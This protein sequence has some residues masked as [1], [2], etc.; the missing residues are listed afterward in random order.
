[1]IKIYKKIKYVLRNFT[2]NE[3]YTMHC[4]LEIEELKKDILKLQKKEM[5]K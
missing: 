4:L 3:K 5:D 2:L 1:M